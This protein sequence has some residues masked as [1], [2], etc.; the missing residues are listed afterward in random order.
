MQSLTPKT[1]PGVFRK[2]QQLQAAGRTSQAEAIYRQILAVAPNLAE[3]HFQMA[4]IARAR[5][6]WAETVDWLQKARS[7]R[8]DQPDILGALAEAYLVTDQPKKALRLFELLERRLPKSAR[9]LANKGMALQQIG[10]FT[11]ARRVLDRALKLEPKSGELLRIIAVGQRFEPGDALVTKMEALWA[12]PSLKDPSRSQLGYALAKAMDDLGAPERAAP[13]LERANA[14]QAE[15]HPYDRARRERE[16]E[17]IKKLA[18]GLVIPPQE[19]GDFA[20]IF[21][22]GMPRSGTT[23]VEQIIAS[24]SAVEGGG[25]L[26]IVTPTFWQARGTRDVVEAEWLEAWGARVERMMRSRVTFGRHVTD[27]SIMTHALLGFAAAAMPS[28]RFVVVTRDPRDQLYSVWR[29]FFRPGTHRYASNWDSMAHY[30]AGYL[31]LLEFWKSR[32]G[33]RLHTVAYED[34]VA[35]PEPQSRALIAAAGLDWEASCL[36]FHKNDRQVRTLSV[37]QVRQPIYKSSTG[38]WAKLGDA[39]APL[40]E[41]LERNGVT[42]P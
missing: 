35:D 8:P 26:A 17:Q 9:V 27:K 11:E 21:V 32:M 3:A 31:D 24:H 1:I 12:D 33:D 19:E 40:T 28:A 25:E 7:Y 10:E 15:L 23:L 37:A 20:P 13:Y 22:T 14:I 29:N 16:L 6:D 36:D 41:A 39:L 5:S 2:A 42:L 4:R 30:Y 34:L 38:R 18:E